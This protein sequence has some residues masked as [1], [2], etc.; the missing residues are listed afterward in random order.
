MPQAGVILSA[1]LE[2]LFM[3]YF[4]NYF[5]NNPQ[6]PQSYPHDSGVIYLCLLY[7]LSDNL[8]YFFTSWDKRAKIMVYI[9]LLI[10]DLCKLIFRFF[11]IL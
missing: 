8:V 6:F 11:M 4:E 5:H 9:N 10:S 3:R 1:D 2:C 7:H